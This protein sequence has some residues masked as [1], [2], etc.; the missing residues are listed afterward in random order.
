[1]PPVL[2]GAGVLVFEVAVACQHA[3]SYTVLLLWMWLKKYI[4]QTF[5]TIGLI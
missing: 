2:L 4:T 3:K 5:K 1:M